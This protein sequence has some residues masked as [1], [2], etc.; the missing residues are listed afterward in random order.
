MDKFTQVPTLAIN[1]IADIHGD[2]AQGHLPSGYAMRI[3]Y[4]LLRG[5]DGGL[6]IIKEESRNNGWGAYL[7]GI[8]DEVDQWRSVHNYCMAAMRILNDAQAQS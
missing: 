7:D 6:S 5:N 8:T 3:T 4:A 1:L 2:D